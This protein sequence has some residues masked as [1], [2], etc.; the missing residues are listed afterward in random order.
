MHTQVKAV[1][2][3]ELA[4][5]HEGPTAVHLSWLFSSS[6]RLPAYATFIVVYTRAQRSYIGALQHCSVRGVARRMVCIFLPKLYFRR[7]SLKLAGH[8]L[9]A[10]RGCCGCQP[11]EVCRRER[12][13]LRGGRRPG[14]VRGR[15]GSGRSPGLPGTRPLDA[16]RDL[17]MMRLT[18]WMGLV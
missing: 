16:A 7:L 18:G 17:V 12:C 10:G 8:F 15:R 11:V 14:P 2:G 1:L 5:A 6:S 4:D 9:C 3:G 13:G